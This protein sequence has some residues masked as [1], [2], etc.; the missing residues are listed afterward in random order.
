[1]RIRI[2]IHEKVVYEASIPSCAFFSDNL[3]KVKK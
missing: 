3:R 2:E 1:K